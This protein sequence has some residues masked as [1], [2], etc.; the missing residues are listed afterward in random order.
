LVSRLEHCSGV[1]GSKPVRGDL[2]CMEKTP[3]GS[4]HICCVVAEGQNGANWEETVKKSHLYNH[5]NDKS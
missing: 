2:C 3:Q 4:L 1:E 5:G